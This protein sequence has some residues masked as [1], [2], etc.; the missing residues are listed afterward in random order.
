MRRALAWTFGAPLALTAALAAI[1]LLEPGWLVNT[2]TVS[3]AVKRF[4]GDY[5]PSW[6]SFSFSLRSP[7]LIDK[8]ISVRTTDFCFEEKS[9]AA[10][11]CF[12]KIDLALAFRLSIEEKVSLTRLSRLVV[13]ERSLRIDETKSSPRAAPGG[14]SARKAPAPLE[15][16]SLVPRAARA[17]KIDALD[18]ELPDVLVIQSAT[19]TTRA[20][21]ALYY[22]PEEA[23]P[24]SARVD[25]LLPGARRVK[26]RLQVGSDFFATGRL[27]SLTARGTLSGPGPLRAALEARAAQRGPD[28]VAVD[29]TVDASSGPLSARIVASGLHR[30]EEDDVSARGVVRQSTGPLRSVLLTPCRARFRRKDGLL[31]EVALDCD[32]R[33]TLAEFAVGFSSFPRA[34]QGS[35]SA[36]AEIQPGAAR[37]FSGRLTV[38]LRPPPSRYKLAASISTKFTG[39]LAD[40]PRGLDVGHNLLVALD[41]RFE[42]LARY[43]KDTPY[44]I[45]A[46][47]NA[48]SGPI[49]ISAH[50]DG[51]PL[52]G[53]QSLDYRATLELVGAPQKLDATITG[54]LAARDLFGPARAFE[55]K[56][57]V[58]LDDVA[59]SLPY[60]KIGPPPSLAVDKRIH[61]GS[62]PPESVD[63]PAAL[64]SPSTGSAIAWSAEVKTARPIRLLS[65]LAEEPIPIALSL[66]VEPGK[67]AGTIT[68]Q[69][70]A[71]KLFRQKAVID[72]VT[73]TA[74]AGVPDL[75]LD[76]LILYPTS[77]AT[78]RILLLGST[79]KPQVTLESEPPLTQQE[80]VALLLYGKSPDALD[81]DQAASVGNAQSALGSGAFGLASLYLFASTPIDYVGYDSTTQ[82]YSMKFRLP[83]GASLSVGSNT[84]EESQSVSVRKRL[85]SHWVIETQARR[86]PVEGNVVETILEWF[87]RY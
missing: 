38:G 32:A 72:H 6:S 2:R 36:R 42:D 16:A 73:L 22:R 4:G 19:S 28:A 46:P 69:K 62:P 70:F 23:L 30:S 10:R 67:L 55:D 33:A 31:S 43:L 83:G 78:I 48:L 40:F 8:E 79:A 61:I 37:E 65:N 80:I 9:G 39:R 81:Y 11:G 53:G 49:S 74:T 15:L 84:L 20:S 60:L 68:I 76:G 41:G 47:L 54:V 77:D 27:T 87:E 66:S 59:L 57:A 21:A 1:V 18:V 13:L 64:T 56:T 14:R 24:L 3:W 82:T 35:V 71:A 58:T 17:L 25:A 51:N 12:E 75:A 29:A 85:A 44:S 5:R 63:P 7:S 34:L 26:A 52:A 86:S 45:P 50:S